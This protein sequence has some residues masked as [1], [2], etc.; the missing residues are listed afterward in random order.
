[1]RKRAVLGNA[2]ANSA[3]EKI[4]IASYNVSKPVRGSVNGCRTGSVYPVPT[5]AQIDRSLLRGLARAHLVYD[6]MET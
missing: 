1:M 3:L 5:P 4:K 6:K 2:H